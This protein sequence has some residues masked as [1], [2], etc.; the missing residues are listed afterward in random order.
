MGMGGVRYLHMSK[1]NLLEYPRGPLSRL[2]ISLRSYHTKYGSAFRHGKQGAL[3][4]SLIR[5]M[6]AMDYGE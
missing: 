3:S 2:D 4:A 6:S 5:Y 1:K